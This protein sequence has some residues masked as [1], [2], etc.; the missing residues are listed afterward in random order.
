MYIQLIN[1]GTMAKLEAFI[2]FSFLENDKIVVDKFLSFFDSLKDL[3][4]FS[5]ESAEKSQP[6]L[7]AQKV[8]EKM[9]NKN[10]YIG[11]CTSREYAITLD[12]LK[13]HKILK[14][15]WGNKNDFELK[16]SD[17]L[18]QEI[19]YATAKKMKIILLK[20]DTVRVPGGIQGDLEY[21]D[22]SRNNPE[23]CFNKIN[24]VLSGIT[25]KQKESLT[26]GAA[27]SQTQE[28]ESNKK[29]SI[30]STNN[31]NEW[32]LE[33]FENA[34]IN[35][36]VNK[37]NENEEKIKG[38][39]SKSR[40]SKDPKTK[41]EWEAKLLFYKY[42]IDGINTIDDLIR[43]NRENPGVDLVS[44]HIGLLYS[45]F[46]QNEKAA[47]YF[48]NCSEITDDART[49]VIS[50]LHAS[51][52][53]Y[54]CGNTD[55]SLE[56]FSSLKEFDKFKDVIQNLSYEFFANIFKDNEFYDFYFALVESLL[57]NTPTD[58]DSRFN[59]AYQYSE[60]DEYD[61]AL[62]HYDILKKM[63]PTAI[64]FNNLGVAYE[65]L[66]LDSKSIDA[67][68]K[69]AELGESLAYSNLAK[70]KISAGFLSEADELCKKGIS[71][72][73]FDKRL[74]Y[75]IKRIEEIKD[76][77][78]K[79]KSQIFK[80]TQRRRN[81]YSEFGRNCFAI[82]IPDFNK[83]YIG[84]DFSIDVNVHNYHFEG[85]GQFSKDESKKLIQ[86]LS[87]ENEDKFVNY[88]VF[89]EGLII[90]NS[91]VFNQWITKEK[92][93]DKTRKPDKSGLMMILSNLE[94]IEVYEKGNRENE[95]FYEFVEEK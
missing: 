30:K 9:E 8:N 6:K 88:L 86:Y 43:L 50:T 10:I 27:T 34:I 22:F 15:M 32:E 78:E 13:G 87:S 94:H 63:K 19:G 23:K 61:L 37:N 89:Y 47:E 58:Y 85:N 29:Q 53:Y 64:I 45:D 17:W 56:F 67:Y 14:V 11:I 36:M 21:I 90:G 83:K 60:L 3:I 25:F 38:S 66:G 52:E 82:K 93:L 77:E 81:F 7:V 26:T 40:Y 57:E 55:K 20:E 74:G 18:L 70:R 92:T 91:V 75:D 84:P 12:K 68:M 49:K 51:T 16:T 5:Y 2:G 42:L 72:E 73:N 71:I 33:D 24:E 95:K 79:K 4:D 35:A 69:S 65:A 62:Y 1:G 46:S 31:T 76:S 48:S 80:N 54:K 39:F 41:I 28:K 44:Y 59:L